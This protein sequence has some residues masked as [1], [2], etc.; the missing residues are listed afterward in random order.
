MAFTGLPLND[1][2]VCVPSAGS[3]GGFL[4]FPNFWK[5]PTLFPSSKAAGVYL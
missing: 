5:P 4:G 3:R 1:W 2:Q